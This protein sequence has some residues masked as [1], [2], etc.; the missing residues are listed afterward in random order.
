MVRA[1]RTLAVLATIATSVSCKTVEDPLPPQATLNFDITDSAIGSQA[2]ALPA[3]QV[4]SWRVEELSASNITG[5]NGTYSFL[6]SGPCS[7]Q[8]SIL[9]PVAFQAACKTSGL[10]LSPGS[11]PRTASLRITLSRLELRAAA[12]PDLSSSADPDGDGIPN[13]S[14]NCPI[15]ANAS[16]DNVN[17]AQ[18]TFKVGDDCSDF[19]KSGKRTIP[20]QD[21]DGVTDGSDNCLWYPN[22][23]VPGE[24]TPTDTDRDGIGDAC[25]RIAPVVLP[26]GRLTIECDNVTFQA[27]PSKIAAFRIDFGRPG[28]LTCDAGFTGCTIDPAAVRVSLAGSTKTFP[29]H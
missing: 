13:A 3:P 9:A 12:R 19:D 7:Y 18:E 23:L 17:A 28:V 1:A 27:E 22:P 20:D 4:V 26:N 5:V 21:L 11:G 25:E 16:Q 29:C 6:F 15:V 24:T 14:D 10:T 8:L 2:A